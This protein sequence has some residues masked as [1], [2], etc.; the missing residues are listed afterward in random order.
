MRM[1]K[2]K[3]AG[4]PTA[5]WARENNKRHLGVYI[6]ADLHDQVKELRAREGIAASH[7]VSQLLRQYFEERKTA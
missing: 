1:L 5:E 3:R 4:S 7:L 2:S 6:D